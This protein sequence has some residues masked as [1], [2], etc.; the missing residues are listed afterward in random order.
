M[1]TTAAATEGSVL[2]EVDEVTKHFPIRS[3]LLAGRGSGEVVHAVDGV[4]F[5][6]RSGETLGLVGESGCGK[7]TLAR[8]VT[9]LHSV[10]AGQIRFKGE[11]IGH[12]S[13]RELRPLRRSI[14]MVFQDPYGSLNPRRRVGS[15]LGDP[16]AIHGDL[17]GAERRRAIQ[18]LMERVGLS[19]EHYN[20]F[21]AEFSGGQRQRI[22]I[23]RA[24]ALRPELVVC[25][26]PV[27]ALDV[28]IQAQILNLL[29]DLQE[30]FG[31]TYL[32]IAH[33]L[34]V[35]RHV[36]DRIAV[37]YLGKFA[38][39]GPV[40]EIYT[41]SRHPYTASLLAAVPL[42]ERGEAGTRRE[43]AILGGDVPTPIRPPSGCRFHPR[44]PK[45]Q[46][47]CRVEEPVLEQ[48]AGDSPDHLTACHFPVVA[49]DALAQA[50]RTENETAATPG[51]AS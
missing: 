17:S 37:M 42:A 48:K 24:L 7:S 13:R 26:E 29:E 10:T 40:E 12:L 32:F 36:S 31:L 1:T 9:A 4:S 23:A 43:Q 28:S 46:D 20:R 5:S 15:I 3:G 18:E 22:G 30:A 19:P 49:D 45:A 35:V 11:E 25:D 33:D 41:A 16:F 51:A 39:V 44:C 27:S 34:S 47:R 8:L 14:Q 6:L 38:E 2:L 50:S 21:P